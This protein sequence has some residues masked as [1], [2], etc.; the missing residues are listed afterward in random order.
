M[1]IELHA[2]EN[3]RG[4][5]NETNPEVHLKQINGEWRRFYKEYPHATEAQI[6]TKIAEIDAKYGE[7]FLPVRKK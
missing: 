5:L 3:L 1:K 2:L 7:H 6:R 4:I